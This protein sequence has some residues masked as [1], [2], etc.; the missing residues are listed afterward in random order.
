MPDFK[1]HIVGGVFIAVVAALVLTVL[2]PAV[3]I[4]SFSELW[5]M[6]LRSMSLVVVCILAALWPDIDTKSKGQRVFYL[7]FCAADTY[8]IFTRRYFAAALL[9]YLAMLPVIVPH[10]G[11]IHSKSAAL[12]F[13]API[14]LLPMILQR[15]ITYIGLPYFIAA[16]LGYLSHLALDHKL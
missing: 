13:C 14:L 9:G 12:V 10:R 16:L 3:A 2:S 7:L 5:P 15:Q 4:R 6:A 11:W 8:L 1:D